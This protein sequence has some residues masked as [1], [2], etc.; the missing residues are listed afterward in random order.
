I[1]SGFYDLDKKTTGFHGNELIIL[2][3][4][5][6]MGKT[7]LALNMAT[8]NIVTAIIMVAKIAQRTPM[9]CDDALLLFLFLF[10][11]VAMLFFVCSFA[12]RHKISDSKNTNNY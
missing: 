8:N 4:R 1:P 6:G 12:T 5:P 2:A 7:S 10:F 11:F 9:I 3:A